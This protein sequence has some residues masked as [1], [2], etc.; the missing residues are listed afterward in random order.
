MVEKIIE[1]IKKY[2][3]L[4]GSE[5]WINLYK[6]LV[7]EEQQ[8][9]I[10]ALKQKDLEEFLDWLWDQF[11]VGVG[12]LYF[13]DNIDFADKLINIFCKELEKHCSFKWDKLEILTDLMETISES[14]F[15]KDLELQTKWEKKYKVIKW[16]NFI[17][18]TQGIKEI[19]K[20][21]DI[22]FKNQVMRK[23]KL[24]DLYG[25]ESEEEAQNKIDDII[26]NNIAEAKKKI[27]I[28]NN[29][30]YLLWLQNKNI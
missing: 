10:E 18:P 21:Y 23:E 5:D 11:W 6:K 3:P 26:Y 8:E 12:S 19:I 25:T 16:E 2:Q 24:K 17:P 30:A 7:E 9:T 15:T 1:W 13:K 22:A 28:P 20:K 4:L 27:N 29:E 14:N